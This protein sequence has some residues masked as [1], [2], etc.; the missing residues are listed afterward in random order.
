M[1]IPCE[2]M[3]AETQCCVWQTFANL[4]K[5]NQ[6]RC[7]HSQ[8][9]KKFCPFGWMWSQL[10]IN[11]HHIEVFPNWDRKGADACKILINVNEW[12]SRVKHS[13]T[14]RTLL[15][16][17]RH[18]P[19]LQC[20]S[21]SR[22]LFSLVEFTIWWSATRDWKITPKNKLELSTITCPL[23]QSRATEHESPHSTL[24][25]F[26]KMLFFV[27]FAKFSVFSIAQNVFSSSFCGWSTKHRSQRESRFLPTGK[28]TIDQIQTRDNMMLQL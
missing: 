21:K 26:S 10:W 25:K 6:P 20:G 18:S 24:P 9:N 3:D 16:W 5:R 13:L 7:C 4:T 23:L 11:V 14:W 12:M 8:K 22:F 2:W 28:P 19:R 27:N 15:N 17:H 1:W